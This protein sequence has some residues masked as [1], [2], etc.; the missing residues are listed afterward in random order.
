[1]EK[2]VMWNDAIFY[3]FLYSI[4]CVLIY[5]AI[6]YLGYRR[7]VN[8]YKKANQYVLNLK[9]VLEDVK[10]IIF[11]E[12]GKMLDK[13]SYKNTRS[14]EY[15]RLDGVS[16]NVKN[17][18]NSLTLT[19]LITKKPSDEDYNELIELLTKLAKSTYEDYK[20]LIAKSSDETQQPNFLQ[21]VSNSSEHPYLHREIFIKAVN[22]S[23]DMKE[24]QKRFAEHVAAGN[25]ID[26][27]E[28]VK[29][30]TD[31]GT[32]QLPTG[33]SPINSGLEGGEIVFIIS[34]IKKENYEAFYNNHIANSEKQG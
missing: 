1:M 22:S 33:V 14:S 19:D 34:F 16:S 28:D 24:L 6:I 12:E 23:V 5:S 25:V 13:G 29:V 7:S 30:I 32:N 20:F 17:Y 31:D 15:L 18:K 11:K 9:E 10:N 3:N 21:I 2:A 27:G 4:V 8:E 26:L